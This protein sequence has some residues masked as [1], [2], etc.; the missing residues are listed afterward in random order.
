MNR[1]ARNRKRDKSNNEYN[2]KDVKRNKRKG[3]RRIYK[4]Y[5]RIYESGKTR[6][7]KVTFQS[8]NEVEEITRKKKY[9]QTLRNRG[10]QRHMDKKMFQ[11]GKER[12][13]KG[14]SRGQK[15]R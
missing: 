4:K 12:I 15:E 9:K 11:P 1:I 3:Y 10:I 13:L 6:I 8:V 2:K 7:L 5:R 14:K